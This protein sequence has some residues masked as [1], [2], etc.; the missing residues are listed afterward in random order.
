MALSA[1][2]QEGSKSYK[3]KTSGLSTRFVF[4][5]EDVHYSPAQWNIALTSV[6]E[7]LSRRLET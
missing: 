1:S 5:K 7:T 3:G 2:K 4:R 6:M